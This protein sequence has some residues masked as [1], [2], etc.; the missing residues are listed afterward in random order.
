MLPK[1]LTKFIELFSKIPGIGLRQA[2]RIAFWFLKRDI[3]AYSLALKD[4]DDKVAVCQQCFF[5]FEKDPSTG[6]GQDSST[7]L[8]TT[9]R[10]C[11]DLNRDSKILA[12]IEKETELSTFSPTEK[13]FF[14]EALTAIGNDEKKTLY[15]VKEYNAKFDNKLTLNEFKLKKEM[16][17]TQNSPKHTQ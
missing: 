17:K 1:S 3:H 12:I 11:R 6:S 16:F 7:P 10:I 2:H 8:E 4:L 15:W 14:T 5:V 13:V 9:C